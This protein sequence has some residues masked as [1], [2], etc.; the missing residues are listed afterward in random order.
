VSHPSLSPLLVLPLTSRKTANKKSQQASAALPEQV[1]AIADP[2][3]GLAARAA[4]AEVLRRGS[5][6]S[7]PL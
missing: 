1:R 7:E 5:Q 4:G 3:A 6:G 2:A